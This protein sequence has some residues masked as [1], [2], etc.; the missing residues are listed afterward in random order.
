MTPAER[1]RRKAIKRREAFKAELAA[2][3][4]LSPEVAA[5][6]QTYAATQAH[7]RRYTP[8]SARGRW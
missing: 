4:P 1:E 6:F 5:K 3:E 7:V 8:S 2:R